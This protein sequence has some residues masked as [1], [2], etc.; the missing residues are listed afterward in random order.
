MFTVLLT[1]GAFTGLIRTLREA[2]PGNVRIV[3]LSPDSETPHQA[4]LDAF[5]VV[6]SHESPN[7]IEE[8]IRIL[9]KEKVHV[10]FPIIS[11]GL[12]DLMQNE[13]LIFEKTGA[14]I[15][16]SPLPSLQIANDK[17]LLY[18]FFKESKD[19]LLSSIIPS[20]SLADTKAGLFDAIHSISNTGKMPCIK[21]RRGED[22]A[23][24]WIIDEQADYASQLF[25]E[26]PQRLISEN[27][28]S[29]MLS[30]VESDDV[31]PPYMASE[32]LPGEE[33]DCDVLCINGR[34]ISVTTRINLSM[35]GG[36]TSVLEV[37]EN[38]FLAD[39]CTRIVAELNL[40]YVVCISF[41]ADAGGRFFLL[42]INPRMMGN[43]YVSAL[44]GNN[45]VKMAVDL[46][47]GKPVQAVVPQ[48]GIKTALYYDQL[49]I[50]SK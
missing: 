46:L 28:L 33:W 7:Y 31:I 24:F 32:F 50:H 3:G 1:D 13:S 37:R 10:I 27:I 25:F 48:A 4:I 49:R 30:K 20:F 5:Y 43:I 41:R 44:A 22:A 16:S 45:Y 15:L 29:D 39:C 18:S 36:L 2:Y 14:R 9:R 42:E 47:Y 35:T 34:L 12:E 11:E 6:P 38:A 26:P 21:R 23:G 17:G 8:L 40:S 19:P